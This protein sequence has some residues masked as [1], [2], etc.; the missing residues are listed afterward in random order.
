MTLTD[1]TQTAIET[2]AK[3]AVKNT[4]S[5][6]ELSYF[7]KVARKFDEIEEKARQKFYPNRKEDEAELES[8]IQDYV[9]ELIANGLSEEDALEKAAAV[10]LAEQPKNPEEKRK[11]AYQAHY[12]NISVAEEEAIGLTYG[13][14]I[15]LGIVIGAMLGIITQIIYTGSLFGIAFGVF[16]VLGLFLGVALGLAGHAKIVKTKS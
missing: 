5:S 8:Y 7:E 4:L 14:R 15:F 9:E 2:L 1:K 12:E 10:I 11:E 16:L 3:K 13:S 6:N